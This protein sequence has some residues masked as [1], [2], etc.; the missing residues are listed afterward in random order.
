MELRLLVILHMSLVV[1]LPQIL[2]YCRWVGHG[3]TTCLLRGAI[4]PGLRCDQM[5]RLALLLL[6]LLLVVLP[7]PL[8]E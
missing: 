1:H 6:L 5:G 3:G 4:Q 2:D 7:S 8:F